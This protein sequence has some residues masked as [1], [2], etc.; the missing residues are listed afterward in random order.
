MD[1][2]G[3]TRWPS[4]PPVGSGEVPHHDLAHVEFEAHALERRPHE[5]RHLIA[6]VVLDQRQQS[7]GGLVVHL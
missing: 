4:A 2:A 3:S 6:D 7:E 5:G 1:G